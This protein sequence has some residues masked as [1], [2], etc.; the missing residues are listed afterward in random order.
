M[1]RDRLGMTFDRLGMTFDRLRMTRD[2]LRMTRDRLRMTFDRLR[3]TLAGQEDK[4]ARGVGGSA[5]Q[6]VSRTTGLN[7]ADTIRFSR[8]A[9]VASLVLPAS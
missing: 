7:P 2:R 3:M 6:Y 1:T 9:R 4:V 8:S 5:F